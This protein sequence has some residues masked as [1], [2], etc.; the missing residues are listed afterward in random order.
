MQ[1]LS[2]NVSSSFIRKLSNVNASPSLTTSLSSPSSSRFDPV[3][4]F[5]SSPLLLRQPSFLQKRTKRKGGDFNTPLEFIRGHSTQH[6]KSHN[7]F[8]EKK[9][10][11]PSLLESKWQ[12]L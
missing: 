7:L 12:R 6:L 1:R 3:L 8:L 10:Y 2:P 9:E 4:Y 11:S 5:A